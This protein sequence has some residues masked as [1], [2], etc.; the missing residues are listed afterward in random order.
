MNRPNLDTVGQSFRV[1]KFRPIVAVLENQ[2]DAI[3]HFP[4]DV[5]KA[6]IRQL[7]L[8]FPAITIQISGD[9]NER[10]MTALADEIRREVVTNS[11]V[12]AAKVVGSRDYEIAIEISES[13]LR[14]YH[15]TLAEVALHHD[16]VDG[17]EI[18]VTG[19][20]ARS[21]FTSRSKTRS[22]GLSSNSR[23]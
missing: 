16:A 22:V 21:S 8:E 18:S 7:D 15:L 11:Q 13:L 14:E 23:V 19:R 12:S 3:Q 9:L 6:I 1:R 10:A 20:V 2:I 4:D 5:E 17:H